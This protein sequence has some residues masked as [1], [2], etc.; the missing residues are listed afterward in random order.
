MQQ[1]IIRIG[2]RIRFRAAT[3]WT[4]SRATRV[5]NG[6]HQGCPTVRFGNWD[7]FVVLLSEVEEVYPKEG[8]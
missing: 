5:V 4:S 6:F 3:L 1:Q 2:D 8:R 7:N